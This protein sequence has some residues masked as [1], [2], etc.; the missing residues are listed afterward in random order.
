MA[1]YQQGE[2]VEHILNKD[3]L[4]VLEVN[5]N[6]IKCRTKSFDIVDFFDHEI[7]KKK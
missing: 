2:I 4:L 5:G 7:R 6:K 3:W 1:N